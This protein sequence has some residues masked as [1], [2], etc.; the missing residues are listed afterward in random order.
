[1][2]TVINVC[3]FFSNPDTGKWKIVGW[4]VNFIIFNYD[5]LKISLHFNLDLKLK[6]IKKVENQEIK[7]NIFL[8][9]K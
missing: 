9:D 3:L 8:G 1:M 2:N 5:I 6:I 7:L 4:I